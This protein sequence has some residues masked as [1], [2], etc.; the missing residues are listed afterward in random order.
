MQRIGLY[1]DRV[2]DLSELEKVAETC[3][4]IYNSPCFGSENTKVRPIYIK[5]INRAPVEEVPTEDNK[6][7][8]YIITYPGIVFSYDSK[9]KHFNHGSDYCISS[10]AVCYSQ[11]ELDKQ[12]S[13]VF[14]G[15]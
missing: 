1:I 10:Q 9:I 13:S 11:E 3:K 12:F 7:V 5:V 2:V 15:S 4:K 8:N 6:R 14:V